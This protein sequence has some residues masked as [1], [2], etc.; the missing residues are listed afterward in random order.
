LFKATQNPLFEQLRDR[1]MQNIFFTQ[2]TEGA[3]RGGVYS[4]ICDPWLERGGDFD[5]ITGFNPPYT[6]EL[7]AD[8]MIQLIEMGLV[9]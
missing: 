6:S 1:V 2:L 8:L 3:Y 5:L 4:A 7:V 9:K